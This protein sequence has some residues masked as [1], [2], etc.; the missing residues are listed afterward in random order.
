MDC[1]ALASHKLPHPSKLFLEYLNNFSKVQAFY[2]H[3]PKI[4]SVTAV[5]RELDFP[6]ERR[7]AVTTILRAQNAAFG[8]GPAVFDNLDRLEKGAVAV[9]S[10]QQVGL[11]SGPA[12]SF[13]KALSAIQVA[14][15]LT[16]SG[17]EAVPVFWMATEDHDVDEVRHVSWFQDGQLKRFE[18][19]A[20][21]E[22][23][24]GRPV[25]N[26]LLGAQIDEQVH[27]AAELLVKQGSV[28]LAQFLK[29]SYSRSETYGSAF[30]KLFAKLFSQQGLILLDPLDPALHRIAAPVYRQ[31]IEYRDALNEKLLRRD[32]E[33]EAAG[34][35]AQVK[36]TAKSTLLF[37]MGCQCGDKALASDGVRKAIATSGHGKFQAGEKQ[38]ATAELLKVI[39][40]TPGDFSP[41]ALLR[42]VVQDFLLP[43]VAYIGGAAEIAYFAQSEVVYKH[44]L[45]R[46]PVILSRPDFTLVDI[47]AA[48]LLRTYKL[49]VEDI[50]AGSQEVRRRME[51]ASVP[52]DVSRDFDRNHKQVMK[53]LG[54]LHD[55]LKKL[56]PTLQ[57]AVETARKKIEYQIDKLRRK[58]GRAQD[59]KATLLAVSENFLEQLLYPHKVLQSRELCLLPFLARWGPGGL[60]ELQKLCGDKNLGRHCIVQLS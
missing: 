26:I 1:R 2:A 29:E 20:P 40:N 59:A 7:N 6:K 34:F 13:Y 48:K 55:Q 19:A 44:V 18:L 56:D 49:N 17:I 51:R 37:Y 14:N 12:Y 53:M 52:K 43:T 54:Q 4:S 8:T 9:V 47:K 27:E 30:A 21:P 10:G 36:V 11:F 16:R 28:L 22:Q 32:K 25:G 15:E 60:T 46:M 24:A 35:S 39:E 45:G 23:D 57:G 3:A 41:S 31:A 5:A 42:A 50:W 38:W 33:L 58:T